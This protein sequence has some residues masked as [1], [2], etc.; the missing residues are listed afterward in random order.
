VGVSALETGLKVIQP[1]QRGA[2]VEWFSGLFGRDGRETTVDLRRADFTPKIL[3]RLVRLAYQHVRPTD[4]AQHESSYS[5]DDRDHAEQGRNTVLSA[6]LATTGTEG[7]AAKLEMAQDPLFANFK[8]RAMAIARERAAEEVD[9][10]PLSDVQ[11]VALDHYGEA[12]PSTRD[13]MFTVMRDRLEDIDDL[14]LEDVSPREAWANITD[15]RVMRREIARELR[16]HA[17]YVYT[18]DQEAATADEKETDI[19][20]RATASPQQATIELKIGDKSRTGTDLRAAIKDQL[21]KKYM[22]AEV[23]RSG[24]L[25]VTIATDKTWTHPDTSKQLN[26]DSLIAML[27]DEANQISAELG[28]SVRLMAKG[29]DLRPRL[30]TER[31]AAK[32]KKKE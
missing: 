27:N 22:A 1:S 11:F 18:V 19:R 28:G 13:G 25:I 26:F 21:L 24:C 17:N 3:L 6:L 31:A 5:P 30:K 8:D 4:D 2:G 9:G 29:L 14:L 16:N 7:W 12:A 23:C 32:A 20:M 15:E 10:A